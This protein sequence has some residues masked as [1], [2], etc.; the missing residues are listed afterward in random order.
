MEMVS[1]SYV[2]FAKAFDSVRHQKLSLL[3]KKTKRG[4][5]KT[6]ADRWE[7]KNYTD[8]KKATEDGSV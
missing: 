5:R 4:R 8:L 6:A 1:Y 2:D 7:K 3:R